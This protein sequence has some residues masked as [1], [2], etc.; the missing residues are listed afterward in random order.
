VGD[1]KPMEFPISFFLDYAWNPERIEADNIQKYTED[2][3]ASQ[4]GNKH[5]KNI[6]NI[7]AKY[8]KYNSRRKPEL[9]DANTYSL[10]NYDE[11]EKVVTDYNSLWQKAE[12]IY[13]ALSPEY[14]DA[15]FQLVLHPV[16]ACANLN[17]LYYNVSLNRAA[18]K[19]RNIAANR[20][21]DN[22]KIFYDN[23]SLITLQYHQLRDGKWNHMM[24][25]AHIGYTYWQ[26]PPRQKMPEVKYVPADS[27]LTQ[28]KLNGPLFHP[29][30]TEIVF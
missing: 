19:D 24:D 22:V 1:I 21:A 18:Y 10:S 2:W 25:Q 17:E 4:F 11:F 8:A 15:Y 30:P 28:I 29:M 12:K 16:K 13:N 20:Y 27:I 5:A 23:D 14:R 7:L 6:A 3:A 26:Q 9:L